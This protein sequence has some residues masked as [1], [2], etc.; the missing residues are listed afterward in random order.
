MCDACVLEPLS[1]LAK[2]SST[3]TASSATRSGDDLAKMHNARDRAGA[4][5]PRPWPWGARRLFTKVALGR[6]AARSGHQSRGRANGRFR[7]HAA[8]WLNSRTGDRSAMARGWHAS[9]SGR[10]AFGAPV[11]F[12][13]AFLERAR[14]S[15]RPRRRRAWV[16]LGL[17]RRSVGP[18]RG[19]RLRT[20][21]LGRMPP[22]LSL[23]LRG[24]R[25]GGPRLARQSVG[26]Q[27]SARPRARG[28]DRWDRLALAVGER[29]RRNDSGV[30][31]TAAAITGRPRA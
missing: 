8:E 2:R 5:R 1:H 11:T 14:M 3:T 13:S 28:L 6:H 30:L 31:F 4:P 16:A 23:T 22:N 18:A 15:S 9:R 29:D 20:R 26:S 7:T 21:D 27:V 25:L 17:A 10:R 24:G 19:P 12:R